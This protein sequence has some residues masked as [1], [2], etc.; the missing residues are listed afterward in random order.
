MFMAEN[1]LE[2]KKGSAEETTKRFYNRQGIENI[3]GF[4]DMLVTVSREIEDIEEVKI[5]TIWDSEECF[6]NWL[7]SDE[8]KEAHKNVRQNKEDSQSPI[9]KNEVSTYSI[10]YKYV[11]Y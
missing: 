9:L 6:K 10:A 7:K 4:K 8:F 2:L 3:E 1:R 11:E 5:L